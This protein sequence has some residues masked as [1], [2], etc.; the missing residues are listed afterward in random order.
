MII[1]LHVLVLWSGDSEQSFWGW[2]EASQMMETA[3]PVK[4]KQMYIQRNEER[5]KERKE[6]GKKE[7]H[8]ETTYIKRKFI[9]SS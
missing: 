1:Q 7:R 5:E 4:Q 3:A 8:K 2:S 6:E 9:H